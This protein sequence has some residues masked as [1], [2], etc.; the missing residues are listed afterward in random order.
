MLGVILFGNGLFVVLALKR[1]RRL[2][3]R[4]RDVPFMFLIRS[5][6]FWYKRPD[7]CIRETH[8]IAPLSR[9]CNP[10]TG[11]T[12]KRGM[13]KHCPNSYSEL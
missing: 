6:I 2:P 7:L 3:L 10:A 8:T 12:V 13:G 5:D 1:D 4:S 9:V 11:W